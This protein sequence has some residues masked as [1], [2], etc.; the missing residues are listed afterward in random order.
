MAQNPAAAAAHANRHSRR[1]AAKSTAAPVAINPVSLNHGA[2]RH[3]S[4]APAAYN[5]RRRPDVCADSNKSHITQISNN[6]TTC[7]A[8]IILAATTCEGKKQTLPIPTTPV[9]HSDV[10]L[11]SQEISSGLTS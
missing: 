1:H 2:N 9:C 5:R 8:A 4:T 10:P 6:P 11:I 7:S 3:S